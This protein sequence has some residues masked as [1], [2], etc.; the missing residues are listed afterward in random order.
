MIKDTLS[1]K[2]I[3]PIGIGTWGIGGTWEKETGNEQKGI[4]A[5]KY[6]IKNGLNHIDSGQIYGGGYT[7]ELIGEAIIKFN[8]KDLYIANKLWETNVAKGKAK[9]AVELMLKKLGTDYI[10]LLY[11]HKPWDD[12]PWREAIP[13]INHLIKS[14]IV[15]Q[16]GVSNFNLAQTKEAASISNYPIAANQLHY[17]VIY[18][19][20]VNLEMKRFCKQNN[21]QIIAYRPLE[22]AEILQNDVVNKIAM[23]NNVSAAQVA[24]A[25]ILNQNIFPIPGAMERAYTKQNILSVNIKLSDKE[26]NQLNSL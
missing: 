1:G 10:D 13:Q 15:R 23:T 2:K 5:I 22:R 18:K 16:F 26:I 14:G 7:D 11:I 3:H 24:L 19:E 9:L 12:F 25:W 17:N 4:D 6:A 20:E 8:R 21:M